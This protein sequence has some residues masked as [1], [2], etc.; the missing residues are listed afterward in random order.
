MSNTFMTTKVYYLTI[1]PSDACCRMFSMKSQLKRSH[2]SRCRQIPSSAVAEE[3]Q[4]NI[5]LMLYLNPFKR[6]L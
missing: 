5:D 2:F 1:A 6:F 4:K 3:Q